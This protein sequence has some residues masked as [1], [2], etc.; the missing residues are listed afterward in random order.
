M[1][2]ISQTEAP[3]M[4]LCYFALN[5]PQRGNWEPGSMGENGHLLLNSLKARVLQFRRYSKKSAGPEVQRA[6]HMWEETGT[7]IT[8]SRE[9]AI[10]LQPPKLPPKGGNQRSVFN[11]KE[12][13]QEKVRKTDSPHLPHLWTRRGFPTSKDFTKK[14]N[15]C[16]QIWSRYLNGKLSHFSFRGLQ[17]K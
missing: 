16:F 5:K 15:P 11:L 9:S 8:M 10:S 17:P 4:E 13:G 1:G 14:S 6:G 3:P 12:T 7:L 2:V